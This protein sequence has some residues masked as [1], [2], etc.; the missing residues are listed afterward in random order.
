MG[1]SLLLMMFA[2]V[3][4]AEK[5]SMTVGVYDLPGRAFLNPVILVTKTAFSPK[6]SI[7][8]SDTRY[9]S[10]TGFYVPLLSKGPFGV[11]T[12][13]ACSWKVKTAVKSLPEK[14]ERG[15]LP[16]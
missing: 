2:W 3:G 12:P 6:Y 16:G 8:S 10:L 9:N 1:Q 5:A 11:V 13:A 14:Q 7:E 4:A 15:F